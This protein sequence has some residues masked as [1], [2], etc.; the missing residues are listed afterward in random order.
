MPALDR[1]S[2]IHRSIFHSHHKNID[3]PFRAIL[4]LWP[5]LSLVDYITNMNW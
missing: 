2:R 4:R 1:D 5:T 3:I